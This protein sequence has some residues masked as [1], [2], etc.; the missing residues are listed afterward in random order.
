MVTIL[1]GT[2]MDDVL[3]MMGGDD[4]DG[5][6][7]GDDGDVEGTPDASGYD[8]PPDVQTPQ[9][10]DVP[11]QDQPELQ[12]KF[13]GKEDRI[14][15]AWSKGESGQNA[16]GAASLAD[17]LASL[18]DSYEVEVFPGYEEFAE[19]HGTP[20]ED[21]EFWDPQDEDYSCAVAT[22][23]MMFRS[24][25]FDPGESLIAEIFEEEGIYDPAEGTDPTN[26]LDAI[27]AVADHQGID[28]QATEIRGFTEE[29]LRNMLDEGVRPLI[30]VDAHELYGG[31]ELTLNEIHG[32]PDSGHAVQAIQIIDLDED[33]V[34]INDP[35]P[36]LGPGQ[37]IPLHRFM[38]AA[39]D[40]D[41]TAVSI[42]RV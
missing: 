31:S 10:G 32:Y 1:G 36:H 23:N 11:I 7:N 24:L 8:D 16:I 29:T 28:I 41:F 42:K 13:N 40:F 20:P 5:Y 4:G 30:A 9:D 3:D 39:N 26:M 34:V 25:G 37:R 17:P 15:R 21:L 6:D 19:T 14:E 35:D 2:K 27:R 38:K 18:S 33:V 22:T 12:V